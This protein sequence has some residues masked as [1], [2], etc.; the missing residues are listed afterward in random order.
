MSDINPVVHFEMGYRDRERMVKF[1]ESVFHSA[2]EF[3]SRCI[4]L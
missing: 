3:L 2:S 4:L 1:Y